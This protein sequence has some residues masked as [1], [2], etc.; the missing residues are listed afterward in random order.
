[1]QELTFKFTLEQINIILTALDEIKHKLSR[2]I[3][4]EIQKQWTPQLKTEVI[5]DEKV[6]EITE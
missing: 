6:E 3:I 1:M 5:D 4:D 2:P